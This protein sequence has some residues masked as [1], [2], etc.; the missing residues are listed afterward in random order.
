[1]ICNL[2]KEIENHKTTISEQADK[3]T[4]MK[5]KEENYLKEIKELKDL[6]SQKNDQ[7]AEIV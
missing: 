4:E 6:L 7:S 3:I 1:M 5:T 2:N